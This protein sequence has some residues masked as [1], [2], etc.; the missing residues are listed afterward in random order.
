MTVHLLWI[1]N[2]SGQ[3]IAKSSFTAQNSIGELGAKPDLQLT[4]SSILFSTFGMSQELTPNANPVDSAGMTLLEFAEHNVHI[5][6]TPSLV[7]FVLVSDHHTYECNALFRQLHSLYVEY[8]VK[9]P[10]NIIDE[11]GIGQ[12][13]RIPA[14]TEAVKEAV[15]KYHSHTQQPAVKR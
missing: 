4:M 15:D 13:I 9:N 8:V 11:G 10:F 7:K 12:P 14:F 2:Q 1:I 6:E 5:Y 3:L